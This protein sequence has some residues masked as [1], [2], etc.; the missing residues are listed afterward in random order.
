V[1]EEI[2]VDSRLKSSTQEVRN[3]KKKYQELLALMKQ[4]DQELDAYHQ[5]QDEVDDVSIRPIG[6]PKKGAPG[7][8]TAV[9]TFSDLHYEESVDPRVV[10]DLNEYNT[11]I[12]EERTG[13]FF[14]N[15]LKLVDMARSKSM[16][17]QL[18][19]W[20]GG[21]LISG[22][23]HEELMESN[24]LSPIDASIR[25][26]A[27]MISGIDYLLEHGEF[28]EIVVVTSVGNHG[29]TTQKRRVSTATQNSYEWMIYNFLA[30][31][32]AN[33]P[34]VRF[35]LSRSYH[36]YLDV[37]DFTLRFHHG[38]NI[39][40]GGGIGGITIPLNKAIA[41]WNE[42][43]KADIDVMGHWHQRI[44]QKHFVVNGSIIGYNAYA[45][46]IKAPFERPQQSFFLVHPRWG[47]TVEAPIFVD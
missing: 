5:F 39:R 35:K 21:D 2:K 36:N 15:S 10:S 23:I 8:S 22:Y 28:E 13:R 33:E 27:L 29:R 30:T 44:S 6:L 26:F 18:V 37:Y 9:I 17:K 40:Y 19:L 11:T 24:Q 25:V 41:S 4:K 45:M 16:I 7:Q 43:R 38:E 34:R 46:S 3:T 12:A 14:E 31:H 20:L 47:K 32:Y 1:E 42:G